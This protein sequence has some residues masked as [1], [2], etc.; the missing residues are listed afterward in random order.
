MNWKPIAYATFVILLRTSF[1]SI[2]YCVYT[3]LL[4]MLNQKKKK[5][6][7]LIGDT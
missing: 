7:T 4:N 1:P 5:K 6:I 3:W 2:I